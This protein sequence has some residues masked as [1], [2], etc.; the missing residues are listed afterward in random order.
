[1]WRGLKPVRPRARAG[2]R[3]H[4]IGEV[5]GGEGEEELA[6]SALD[7]DE[8]GVLQDAEMAGNGGRGNAK[9]GD[10]F[11]AAVLRAVAG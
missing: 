4:L 9:L 7:G 10:E 3:R 2:P 11:L 1:M 5:I 8:I 6:G